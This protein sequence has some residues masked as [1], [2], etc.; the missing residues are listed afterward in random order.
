M[1]LKFCCLCCE[2]KLLWC[3]TR[4]D[5]PGS[6]LLVYRTSVYSRKTVYLEINFTGLRPCLVQQ[7]AASCTECVSTVRKTEQ[8]GRKSFHWRP[9]DKVLKRVYSSSGWLS[10]KLFIVFLK[11][12]LRGSEPLKS[13][14]DYNCKES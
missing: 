3:S 2:K 7:E 14:K 11:W 4:P 13:T 8:L 5:L 9:C 12:I 10:K 6:Y 1:I